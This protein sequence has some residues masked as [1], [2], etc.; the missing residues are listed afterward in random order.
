MA[1]GMFFGLEYLFVS[2]TLPAFRSWH[3]ELFRFYAT[4]LLKINF[5]GDYFLDGLKTYWKY[6]DFRTQIIKYKWNEKN[7]VATEFFH[8]FISVT[9]DAETQAIK[10]FHDCL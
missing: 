5:K 3:Y 4:T 9:H 7:L 8:Q 1:A 6:F 10:N 2:N